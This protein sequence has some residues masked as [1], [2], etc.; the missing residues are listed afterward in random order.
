[1]SGGLHS[2]SAD[3]L[4]G[5]IDLRTAFLR[6]HGEQAREHPVFQELKRVKQY[7]A[8]IKQVEFPDDE[9]T[10]KMRLDREAA[11]RFIKHAL[12][13]PDS[14]LLNARMTFLTIQGF[15]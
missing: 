5:G 4:L 12:V 1:M 15:K 9:D 10:S 3:V 13:G 6:L 8:K 14:P 11:N 7:F 2:Y